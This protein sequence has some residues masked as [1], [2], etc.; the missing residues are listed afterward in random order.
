MEDMVAA[1][2][3]LPGPVAEQA[4]SAAVVSDSILQNLETNC[5]SGATCDYGDGT[6]TYAYEPNILAPSNAWRSLPAI[7]EDDPDALPVAQ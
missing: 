4:P 1:E 5:A 3:G 6:H 2:P 7:A